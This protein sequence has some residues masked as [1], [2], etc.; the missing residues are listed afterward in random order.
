MRKTP[1]RE[2]RGKGW[3][4]GLANITGIASGLTLALASHAG[5]NDD[6]TRP[7]TQL[8]APPRS[9]TARLTSATPP[10]TPDDSGDRLS[11]WAASVGGIGA[12]VFIGWRRR[13]H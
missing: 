6:A 4:R 9:G 8:R 13:G 11:L 10:A 1:S 3:G 5:T 12:M 2:R 7:T